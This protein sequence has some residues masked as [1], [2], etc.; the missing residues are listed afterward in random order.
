MIQLRCAWT[1]DLKIRQI[2]NM[3]CFEHT[4]SVWYFDTEDR[5]LI[6]FFVMLFEIPFFFRD[7]GLFYMSTNLSLPSCHV[8]FNSLSF[9][10]KSQHYSILF[11]QLNIRTSKK[12]SFIKM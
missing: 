3:C 9:L 1:P 4:I 8:S 10:R 7:L 12:V 6:L 2:I 11:F 5:K